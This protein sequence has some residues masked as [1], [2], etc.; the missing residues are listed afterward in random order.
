MP[1]SATIQAVAL[2]MYDLQR[3]I[4]AEGRMRATT[5][6]I[7]DNITTGV[8]HG[9]GFVTGQLETD[10]YWRWV[11]NGRGPG[12]MPP[13]DSIAAWVARAGIAA[14]PWAIAKSIAKR[15]TRNFRQGKTNIFSDGIDKWEDG[16]SIA[17][18]EDAAGRELEDA[19]I[20]VLRTNLKPRANG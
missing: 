12:K 3:I 19:A 16:A 1:S 15:G 4:T 13:V 10:D 2:A 17:A 8:A 14:S 18:A 20:D 11:G 5:G 7:F 6:G 9:T